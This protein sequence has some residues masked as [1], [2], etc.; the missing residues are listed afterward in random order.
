M[1][2]FVPGWG[3]T[4]QVWA[5]F[6]GAGDRLLASGERLAEELEPGAHVV[7][8]SLGA[9]RA[10]VAATEAELGSLTLVAASGRFVRGDG[11]PLGWPERALAR[12]RERLRASTEAVLD[13]FWQ[14]ALAAGEDVAPPPREHDFSTLDRDLAFLAAYSVLE[15]ASMIS[16][17]VRLLHGGEDR[18]CPPAAAKALAASLPRAELTIWPEAGHAP[19]LSQPDRFRSWLNA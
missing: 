7:G 10:L 17:P 11:Y 12:M 15:R 8:W 5:P 2:I 6:A 9:M 19:F 3:S 13:E 16:C 1:R 4:G 18:I 14:L